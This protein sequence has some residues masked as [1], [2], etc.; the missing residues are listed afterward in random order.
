M[1]RQ[2]EIDKV[3]KKNGFTYFHPLSQFARLVEE[4]GELARILNHLYG[5]KPKK[6][7][8]KKQ[9]LQEEM[10]DVLF[11]LLCLANSTGIDLDKGFEKS[12][13]K[14]LSRDKTR[15]KN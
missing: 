9:N 14:L 4:T 7:S 2:K 11:T 10:G 6:D 8:E 1:N 3:F 12:I 15:Y 5:D 13:K